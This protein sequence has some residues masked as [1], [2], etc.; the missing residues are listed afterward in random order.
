[1]PE[2]W[3][4]CALGLAFRA[5]RLQTARVHH[6]FPHDPSLLFLPQLFAPDANE[7][8]TVLGLLSNQSRSLYSA[9]TEW[10]RRQGEVW[11]LEVWAH[12]RLIS[13]FPPFKL[14]EAAAGKGIG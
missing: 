9:V 11:R 1:M 10:N 12:R 14:T 5:S 3:R 2:E 13:V 6:G 7:L 8:Q 4:G